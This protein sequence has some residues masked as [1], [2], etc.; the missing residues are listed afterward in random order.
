MAMSWV[1]EKNAIARTT[2]AVARGVVPGSTKPSAAID[3]TSAACR[4]TIQ[5]RRR[6]RLARPGGAPRS[7][8]GAQRNLNE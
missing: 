5:P 1:A 6:P 8:R 4:T 7:S 2:A 3:A